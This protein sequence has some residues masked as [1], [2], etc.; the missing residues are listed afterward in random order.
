[1]PD[2]LPFSAADFSDAVR[3]ASAEAWQKT[4]DKTLRLA[5]DDYDAALLQAR[6]LDECKAQLRIS[7]MG[8]GDVMVYWQPTDAL[9][10]FF[11]YPR[12]DSLR[13]PPVISMSYRLPT[14]EERAEL[15]EWGTSAMLFFVACG[16]EMSGCYGF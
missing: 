7:D 2:L 14:A 1:M 6:T 12:I 11:Q 8:D 15:A 3:Q 10:G 9:L 4:V 13:Y 5:L 16:E